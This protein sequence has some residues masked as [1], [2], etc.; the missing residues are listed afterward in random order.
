MNK[1][2]IIF[3]NFDYWKYLLLIIAFTSLLTFV[4]PYLFLTNSLYYQSFGEQL[5]VERISELIDLSQKWQWVSYLLIPLIVLIRISFT[6][7]SLYI[8]FYVTEQ[9]VQFRKLFK[10]ALVADFVFVVSGIVKLLILI[11]FK[12]V[13]NLNDLQFQ[14][15]SVMQLLDK[16]SVEPY[17]I[18]PLSVISVFE[19]L[20]W[21]VLARLLADVLDRPIVKSFRTVAASYGTGLL[22]WVLVGMFLTLNLT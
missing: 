20:Y 6:A 4:I 18:Y 17:L 5:S 11:F 8:G 2:K 14:P 21:I 15:F 13:S 12:E 3:I 7:T 9:P 10:I 1:M 16:S 19:L 22:L